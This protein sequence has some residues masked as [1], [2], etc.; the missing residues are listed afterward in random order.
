MATMYFQSYQ[1]SIFTLILQLKIQTYLYFQSYQ[2]SIFT[3]DLFSH[4]VDD[5][6]TF[7]PI[8]VLFLQYLGILADSPLIDFQSYQGSIFTQY[9]PR[10]RIF[11]LYSFNP[12]KVLFLPMVVRGKK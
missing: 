3:A 6:Y 8:K 12:I 1:G 4:Y 9:Q 11:Y 10:T 7:N 5:F 2:G